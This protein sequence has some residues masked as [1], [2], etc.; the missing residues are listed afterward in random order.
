MESVRELAAE[1]GFSGYPDVGGQPFYAAVESVNQVFLQWSE[2][3]G[4]SGCWLEASPTA[5]DPVSKFAVEIARRHRDCG[6]S[7]AMFMGL[8]KLYRHSYIFLVEKECFDAGSL[9]TARDTVARFFDCI[10][11]AQSLA[12]V[13]IKEEEGQIRTAEREI[14]M[15]QEHYRFQTLLESL[16]NPVF[17][18][19]DEMGIEVMNRAAAEFL[20]VGADPGD[21]AYALGKAAGAEE[22]TPASRV[23]LG[24]VLPWLAE[25]MSKSCP[26]GKQ[27]STRFD[28]SVETGTG[29]SHYNVSISSLANVSDVYTGHTVVLDDISFRVE[30]ERQLSLERNRAAHYLD[31]VGAIV[32]ALDASCGITLINKSG[33]EVLGY[34]EF[35]LL[36][37]DWV[38][39]VI[40][41]EERDELKDYF[42]HLFSEGISQD[43]ERINHV[44]TKDGDL[45]LISWKNKLLRNEGGL[46]IGILCSGMD[47]TE[48]RATEDA[49][50]EKELWLRNTFLALG[51]AVLILTPDGEILDA[52]PVA[53]AM[54][55]MT[56]DEICAADAMELHVDQAHF[57]EYDARCREAFARGE[58]AR[59]EFSRKR[60]NGDIFPTEHSVSMI[61][62]DD[63]APLGIVSVTR[64]ISR[65][66]AAE[67]EIRQSEEKFRRIFDSIE[68]GYIV[69][70][71]DGRVQMVNPATCSLLGYEDVELVGR[72]MG[73]LYNSAEERENFVAAIESQ[74]VV[75]GFNLTLNRKGGGTVV[76][77]ANAHIVWDE[78]GSPVAMEGTFRDITE[79]IEAEK[80]LR[81]REKQYRAF[82]ENN[83]AVMLLVDPKTEIIVDANPAAGH[84]YGYPVDQMRSMELSTISAQTE[85]EIYKEMFQARDEGRVYFILKHRLQNGELRDVE[86]YSG[87]ILVQGRQLLYSVIHD[88]TERIR[89]EREMKHMATTDALT[90][91]N[92]RRQFF[93][94]ASQELKRAHRYERPLTVLMLDIDYFKSINDNYGHHS[95]DVVL[96]AFAALA[97]GTLREADILGRIGGEEFA[98]VLPETP[99][100]AGILVAERLRDATSK[101]A[102]NAKDADINFTISIGVS[103]VAK[104]DAI[105]ED[106][107]NRADEA[108][109]KAKRMGRNRVV[110]G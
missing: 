77:E 59:F 6:V 48:Q 31:V 96:K 95:G 109:Y 78:K 100:D 15:R 35:E 92:N 98:A 108:L 16:G 11:I 55:Q 88:V 56:N 67:Q 1:H 18:L 79:R 75:R 47:I 58:T 105:I 85:E 52:N 29:P 25:E 81:E 53:E 107:I 71:M 33:C 36:G 72:D 49:L 41:P 62:G 97:K 28:V 89:L 61:I 91:L 110:K 93:E 10:E 9:K 64:D 82:F 94:L 7:P 63:G 32:L 20:G 23:S 68:E 50:A 24:D 44:L 101:L 84:F 38:N 80:I 103:I 34:G 106:A 26:I 66:K 3:R 17:M 42:Y 51:E 21:L 65:R 14:A 43:D 4:K 22:G 69:A 60:K 37:Q 102:V 19:N 57:E 86:V 74:G 99:L 2:Q 83:H 90:E 104:E 76:A 87:P 13:K 30:M 46:P 39:F 45:R 8:I 54:F 70:S 27:R 73:I 12:W 40:P 5:D